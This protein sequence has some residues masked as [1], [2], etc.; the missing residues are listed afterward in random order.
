MASLGPI[1]PTR[2]QKEQNLWLL[3]ESIPRATHQGYVPI[4]GVQFWVDNDVCQSYITWKCRTRPPTNW[5]TCFRPFAP[6]GPS[7][8]DSHVAWYNQGKGHF[9]GAM[10]PIRE[11]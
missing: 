1:A 7:P 2:T 5:S 3:Q 4:R 9:F 11:R 6:S 8:G 10:Y